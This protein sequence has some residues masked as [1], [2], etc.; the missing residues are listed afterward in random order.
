MPGDFGVSGVFM[1]SNGTFRVVR[2]QNG[3]GDSCYENAE[4][5]HYLSSIF[6]RDLTSRTTR[7]RPPV[8]YMNLAVARR[9]SRRI[10]LLA[11]R[12]MAASGLTWLAAVISASNS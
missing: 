8:D 3:D 1:G 11:S 6:L 12:H 10:P 7:L 9:Q 4:R 2:V 5:D